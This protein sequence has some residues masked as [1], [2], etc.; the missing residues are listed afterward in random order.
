MMHVTLRSPP[1]I[2]SL[3]NGAAFQAHRN[4]KSETALSATHTHAYFRTNAP[5]ERTRERDGVLHSS[6]FRVRCQDTA[7]SHTLTRTT[8]VH[9][10]SAQS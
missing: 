5:L 8:H 7:E 1:H 3:G 2:C 6:L 4:K 10:H 9:A